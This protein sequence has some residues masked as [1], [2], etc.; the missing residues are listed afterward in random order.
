MPAER[1]CSAPGR[2]DIAEPTLPEIRRGNPRNTI[3]DASISISAC[4]T[5]VGNIKA[6]VE[7]T[8]AIETAA[9]PRVEDL[10]RR[11]RHPAE[12]AKSEAR[13]EAKRRRQ[14]R[15]TRPA[16]ETSSAALRSRRDTT[17]SH[18]WRPRTSGH[19]GTAP[20]PKARSQP[21][22]SHTNP[23]RPTGRNRKAPIRPAPS[24]A[25]RA[26]SPDNRPSFRWCRDPRHRT[27]PAAHV[28]SW[29]I[30]RSPGCGYR[31][32]GPTRRREPPR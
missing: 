3:A 24:G 23:P 18:N 32:S 25:T 17:A 21:T 19:S 28:D 2:A 5:S 8:G 4:N 22:S 6:S 26:R 30:A 12:I 15:R 9:P 20:S 27:L 14:I 10:E 11:Q 7:A 16:R 31:T 1:S 29:E 13:T